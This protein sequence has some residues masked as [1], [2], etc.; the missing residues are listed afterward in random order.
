MSTSANVRTS[1]GSFCESN[2]GSVYFA[3]GD[4]PVKR[5]DGLLDDFVN[6]GVPAPEEALTLTEVDVKDEDGNSVQSSLYGTYYAY[7]R[8][9]DERGNVSNV[10]PLAG[11]LTL[12]GTR[13]NSIADL[14]N[15]TSG[16]SPYYNKWYGTITSYDHG[17][18]VGDEIH[19][20]GLPGNAHSGGSIIGNGNW[21]VGSIVNKDMFLLRPYRSRNDP[22]W[23]DFARYLRQYGGG[24]YWRVLGTGIQYG[25]VPVPTDSRVQK[26]QILRNKVFNVNTF[27]VDIEH[28]RT[29]W[30]GHVRE[31]THQ[32]GTVYES[33]TEDALLGEEVPLR[34]VDGTDLNLFR[35]GEPPNFKK[36][37]VSHYNRIFAAGNLHYQTGSAKV[38]AGSPVVDGNG[39]AWTSEMVGRRFLSKSSSSSV[40]HEIS[41]VDVD[42]QRITLSEGFDGIT[43]NSQDYS[44][45]PSEEEHLSI[46]FSEALLPESWDRNKVVRMTDDSTSGEMTAMFP[47]GPRLFIGFEH[48]IYSLNYMT[49][50]S[51]DG[52]ISFSVSRGCA[53]HRCVIRDGLRAYILDQRGVYAFDGNQTQEISEPVQAFFSGD[54]EYGINWSMVEHFHAAHSAD[55]KIMRW[56]VSVGSFRYPRHALAFSYKTNRWW[57]EEYPEPVSSSSDL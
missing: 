41:A 44:I 51:V 56:F 32:S 9:L 34:A 30:E 55:E 28:T 6:A 27:Y 52:Q 15:L 42:E 35:H 8:F 5:W 38:I 7:V 3:R 18:E 47:L 10:S 20:D 2:N 4:Q 54:Y 57:L 25:N 13:W 19:I 50:P 22:N 53:N 29:D 45:S 40:S 33:A 48:C 1:V 39:T 31:G 37:I 14:D 46:H 43:G 23:T 21:I 49:D 16:S 26:R 12:E 24:G 11:P 36:F 17:L